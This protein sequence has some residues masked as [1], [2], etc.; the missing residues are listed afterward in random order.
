MAA[1][2][3]GIVSPVVRRPVFAIRLRPRKIFSLDD[4]EADGILTDGT[5]ST[6]SAAPPR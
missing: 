3:K 6:Q 2:S 1:D 5:R 4:Y